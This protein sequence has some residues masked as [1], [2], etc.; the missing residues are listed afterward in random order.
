MSINIF[1]KMMSFKIGEFGVIVTKRIVIGIVLL[2]LTL[3]VLWYR[4]MEIPA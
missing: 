1:L 4:I 2:I 3:G